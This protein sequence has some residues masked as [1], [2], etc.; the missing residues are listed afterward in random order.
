M[1]FYLGFL[2]PSK[3]LEE[4]SLM[5]WMKKKKKFHR[6][7]KRII[8]RRMKYATFYSVTRNDVEVK[9]EVVHRL[10]EGCF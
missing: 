9:M 2:P 7:A 1:D 10:K 4:E 3:T 8:F 6:Y 5:K